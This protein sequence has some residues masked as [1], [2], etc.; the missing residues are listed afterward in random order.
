MPSVLSGGTVW[1]Q[2]QTDATK[3]EEIILKAKYG[4]S[5]MKKSN[6]MKCCPF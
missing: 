1:W 4:G 3:P 2:T 5:S 6:Q